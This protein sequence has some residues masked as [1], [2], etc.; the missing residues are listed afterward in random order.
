MA[1]QPASLWRDRPPYAPRACGEADRSVPTGSADLA[2]F[3]RTLSSFSADSRL[4][5]ERALVRLG[6]ARD[7]PL[8]DRGRTIQL[9]RAG[10]LSGSWSVLSDRNPGLTP[11]FREQFDVS[12][13]HPFSAGSERPA[14]GAV[15]DSR[16]GYSFIFF[17]RIEQNSGR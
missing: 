2:Y 4:L 7:R 12:R 13:M 16:S 8:G 15:A 10:R 14:N 5:Q 3:A 17:R 1:V 6:T 11:V 9:P